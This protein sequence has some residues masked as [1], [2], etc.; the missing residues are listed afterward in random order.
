MPHALIIKK[1]LKEIILLI[2]KEFLKEIIKKN[3]LLLLLIKPGS[4]PGT[5][6][7]ISFPSPRRIPIIILI[8]IAGHMQ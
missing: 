2:I 4:N 7:R 8:P 1:L 3:K 6:T 5:P